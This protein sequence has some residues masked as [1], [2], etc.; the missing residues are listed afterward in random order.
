MSIHNEGKRKEKQKMIQ[1]EKAPAQGNGSFPT[2][3][4]IRRTAA[5]GLLSEHYLRQLVARGECPGIR[6][7]NRFLVNLEALVELLEQQSRKGAGES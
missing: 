6:T 2:F 7:G 4:T 5:T 3:L 1:Q